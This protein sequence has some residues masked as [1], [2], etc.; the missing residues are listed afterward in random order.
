MGIGFAGAGGLLVW[1][2]FGWIFSPEGQEQELEGAA[3]QRGSRALFRS[4]CVFEAFYGE[5]WRWEE[6]AGGRALIRARLSRGFWA[7]EPNGT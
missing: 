5:S 2:C 6:D 7:V 1:M 4:V 3:S